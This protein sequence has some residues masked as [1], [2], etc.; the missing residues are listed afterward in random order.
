MPGNAIYS[1]MAATLNT[2]TTEQNKTVD[3]AVNVQCIPPLS[4]SRNTIAREQTL[5]A[6]QKGFI[7]CRRCN[8][9]RPPRS[10][11]CKI[12][13]R[14][15]CRMDHHCPMVYN[16]IGQNNYKYFLLTIFYCFIG[17][18]I[19]FF[20]GMIWLNLPGLPKL[21]VCFC[22]CLKSIFVEK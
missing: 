15:C 2:D 11:H 5:E 4:D 20:S 21:S 19:G 12:C 10:H 6:I 7:I 18:L 17:C 22:S 1:E 9:P 14:C 16:C 13:D 3:D 8:I